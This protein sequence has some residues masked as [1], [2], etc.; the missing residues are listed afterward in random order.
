MVLESV[1]IFMLYIFLRWL[2]LRY[3]FEVIEWEV[4]KRGI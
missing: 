4:E 1:Q 2:V 3:F